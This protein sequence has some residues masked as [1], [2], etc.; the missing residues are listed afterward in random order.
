MDREGFTFVWR[1]RQGVLRCSARHRS[2]TTSIQSSMRR[3]TASRPSWWVAK[4]NWLRK[5]PARGGE[6]M[7]KK[8]YLF[9]LNK[10]KRLPQVQCPLE[11]KRHGGLRMFDVISSVRGC[12]SL[13]PASADCYGG[14]LFV[15]CFCPPLP[16]FPLSKVERGQ[17]QG[18]AVYKSEISARQSCTKKEVARQRG[19][20]A[21]REERDISFVVVSFLVGV[22]AP[23][24]KAFLGGGV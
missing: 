13:C 9:L 3:E 18:L 10:K 11:K 7:R 21:Q 20:C 23:Q 15:F 12:C 16:P 1:R 22:L 17:G 4:G 6:K 8:T 14:G 19:T 5:Q 24:G 2:G